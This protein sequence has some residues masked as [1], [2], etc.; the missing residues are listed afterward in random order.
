[1]D[2]SN[3]HS[4][5]VMALAASPELRLIYDTAP[6]GLAFLTPD[7][8]YA[9]I[10]QHLTEI[11]GISVADH[12]GRS[13]R[14]C[15]PKVADQVEQLV[16]AIL[17]SG[18]PVTGVEINGQRP[19][20]S[21]TDQVW[22]TYWHPLKNQ[23]G[24]IL[25]INVA[26]EEITERKR[27]EQALAASQNRLRKLNDTLAERVEAQA[28]E[29]DR[30][31][32]VSQDLLTVTDLDGVILDINPAWLSTLGWASDELIGNKI[33]EFVSSADRD[34]S[35]EEF[36]RLLAGG[37]PQHFENRISCKDGSLRWLAWRAVL[38]RGQVY[39]V[40]RDVTNIRQTQEELH[41]LQRTLAYVSRD[42][43]MGIMT[44]SLAHEIRQP[45]AV[46]VASARAGLRWLNR[47]E[48]DLTE[49]Q[50]S[51]AAIAKEGQRIDDIIS[52][53]RAMFSKEEPDSIPLDV[54]G[55]V[56]DIL[57]LAQGEMHSK[58]ITLRNK[59]PSRLPLVIGKRVQLQQ[60]LLN[61]IMNA[62]EAMSSVSGRDRELTILAGQ[63][64]DQNL[65]LI[66]EDTGCGI[67]PVDYERIFNTFFTTKQHGMGMGLFICR[68]IIEA[69]GGG[70]WAL[71]RSPFGTAFHLTLPLDLQAE[72]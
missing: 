30:I 15:V 35:Y 32:N 28:K 50:Q 59:L 61:L 36:R 58:N 12:I 14:E 40:G 44:A 10:N 8:R 42:S 34:R 65:E 13:V 43:T 67:D 38:D 68:S 72:K 18:E 47:A 2:G 9:L 45:L 57:A 23:S 24:D 1:M 51:L 6:I 66:V 54:G 64:N 49:A 3:T 22:I 41:K 55:L 31:W 63:I 37:R 19:D 46:I 39:A 56:V 60:V 53:I 48:P 25:G 69:H 29:R 11:C 4:N 27:A 5:Q 33:E 52:S 20:G 26:A 21:N 16:Q 71:P 17:Q 62:I 70:L 7:C